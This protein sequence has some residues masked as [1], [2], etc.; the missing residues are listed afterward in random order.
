[1]A[2]SCRWLHNDRVSG[3]VEGILGWGVDQMIRRTV[4]ARFRNVYWSPPAEPISP[5]AIL[6]AS[7]HG[8]HDGYLLYLAARQLNVRVVD[9]I[10][11]FDAFPLF[12]KVGGMPFP[13]DD[14]LR[15]SATIRRTIRLM[16][17]E[18]RS[19]LLFA[20]GHLHRPPGLL[21]FG[22]SLELVASKVPGVQIQ[23]VAIRYDMSLHERPEAILAFGQTCV[24][25]GPELAARTRRAVSELQADVDQWLAEGRELPILVQG[26]GDVNERL[27]ARRIREKIM[28]KNRKSAPQLESQ[29]PPK[30]TP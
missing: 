19:L 3:Q 4:R 29:R 18:R 15:R 10:A 11:E 1:M 30:D 16:R 7:H 22:K 21:E 9:W 24:E 13:P 27:D 6:V 8:W 5:P 14:P 28:G 26:T 25:L 23:P 20:E 12:A 2:H 17:E